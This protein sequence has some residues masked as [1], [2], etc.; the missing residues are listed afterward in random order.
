MPTAPAGSAVMRSH[1]RSAKAAIVSD[2]LGPTGPGMTEPSA[3]YRP[4]T[5]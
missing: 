4:G 2:G 1:M 5:P 3:T